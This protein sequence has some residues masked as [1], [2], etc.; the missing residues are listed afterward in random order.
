[1]IFSEKNPPPKCQK[2]YI[3]TSNSNF[4]INQTKLYCIPQELGNHRD[5]WETC[6]RNKLRRQTWLTNLKCE[7]NIPGKSLF[8][9]IILLQVPKTVFM[10][11]QS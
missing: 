6:Q 11:V 9:K 2:C 3:S 8:V 1:M 10:Y 7:S 5:N 4:N